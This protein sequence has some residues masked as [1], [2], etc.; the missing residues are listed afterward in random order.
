MEHSPQPNKDQSG[1]HIA[2]RLGQRIFELDNGDFAFMVD[3]RMRAGEVE[4]LDAANQELF[5]P[6]DGASM[7]DYETIGTVRREDLIEAK[8]LIPDEDI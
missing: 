6:G 1:S 3:I 8:P 7:A 2:R 5:D 4:M